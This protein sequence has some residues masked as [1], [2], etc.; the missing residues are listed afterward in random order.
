MNTVWKM[1][2][3]LTKH[4]NLEKDRIKKLEPVIARSMVKT[5]M[6]NPIPL[7]RQ[8]DSKVIQMRSYTSDNSTKSTT[9]M[10]KK[11]ISLDPG[12]RSFLTGWSPEG[13]CYYFGQKIFNLLFKIDKIMSSLQSKIDDRVNSLMKTPFPTFKLDGGKTIFVK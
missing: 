5:T 10:T 1:K 4:Q 3:K 9:T 13:I 8:Y 6:G 2:K 11:W 12:L 7:T